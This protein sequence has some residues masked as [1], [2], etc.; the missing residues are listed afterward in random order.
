MSETF[1]NVLDKGIIPFIVL[2]GVV[3][4]VLLVGNY[5]VLVG[6]YNNIESHSG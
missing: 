4:I 1:L 6:H 2:S 5:I 3:L